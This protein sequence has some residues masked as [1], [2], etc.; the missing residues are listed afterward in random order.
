MSFKFQICMVLFGL[1]LLS[2]MPVNAQTVIEN[3]TAVQGAGESVRIDSITT[4]HPENVIYQN[5]TA[6]ADTDPSVN[7]AGGGIYNIG[8]VIYE[9][10]AAFTGNTATKTVEST[11]EK[12]VTQMGQP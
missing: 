4:T 7:A 8:T 2:V 1:M 3:K 11:S 12:E 5:N 6:N 9:G 10:T